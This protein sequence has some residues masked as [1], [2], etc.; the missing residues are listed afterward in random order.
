MAVSGGPAAGSVPDRSITG[1]PVSPTV[2]TLMGPSSSVEVP[3]VADPAPLGLA[4]FG[5]TTLVLSVINAGW[6][7]AAGIPAVLAMALPYGGAAQALAG[8]WAFRRGNTFAA[9]A[10]TSFGAFWITFYFLAPQLAAIK[11]ATTEHA[12]LGT[13]LFAWGIFT[14]YMFIASLGGAKAVS[15]VFILLAA[16]F[17]FL[18][19]G[20]WA[21]QA[22]GSGWTMIG[23]YLGLA[24]TVVALYTSFA[25]VLN[26]NFK[27]T[28]LPTTY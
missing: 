6:I 3:L 24:T 1:S 15:G 13:Y 17:V 8:M 7:P 18:A 23:G 22:F 25:D 26:A 2:P 16:T 4:A 20:A 14:A 27:R 5:L 19:I 21:G 9:T 11:P 28:I 10:F 12:I